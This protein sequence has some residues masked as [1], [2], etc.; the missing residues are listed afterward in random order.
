M[1]PLNHSSLVKSPG[2]T[3]LSQAAMTLGKKIINMSL[4]HVRAPIF[5]LG[6]NVICEVLRRGTVKDARSM[7]AECLDVT[8]CDI[9]CGDT[10]LPAYTSSGDE[11]SISDCAGVDMS[12]HAVACQSTVTICIMWRRWISFVQDAVYS[13]PSSETLNEVMMKAFYD[14]DVEKQAF[15]GIPLEPDGI[16]LQMM[17]TIRNKMGGPV[18]AG[19]GLD[20]ME[21][22]NNGYDMPLEMLRHHGTRDSVVVFNVSDQRESTLV[23]SDLEAVYQYAEDSHL[24]TNLYH[25]DPLAAW[26]DGDAYVRSWAAHYMH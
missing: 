23:F 22:K 9:V 20:S 11:V 14:L 7:A 25:R 26:N 18:F 2:K 10:I 16:P 15:S 13:G 4:R 6:G 12:L 8:D 24:S 21:F 3:C 5:S 19:G 1:Q 17:D